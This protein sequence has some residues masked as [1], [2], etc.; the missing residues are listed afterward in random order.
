[1]TRSMGCRLTGF[2]CLT[3]L[4]LAQNASAIQLNGF[5]AMGASETQGTNF[6]GSW[7]P[8]L[9]VDRGLNFGPG[10]KY[11]RAIG[12][13]TSQDLLNNG[14]HTQ[15]ASL[16]AG[17]YVDLAFLS[18][19]G[20]DVPPVAIDM[21]LNP[22]Y[23]VQGWANGV[24][25][26]ILTAVDTVKN[27]GAKGMVVM[28]LPDMSLIPGAAS[29]RPFA[30]PVV[31][32]IDLVNEML[33]QEVLDR[34]FVFVDAAQAMRDMFSSPLVVGGVTINTQTGS[35][36]PTHFFVDN[37]HPG[38]VGN[39]IFANLFLTALNLGYGMNIAEFTDQQILTRAG[40]SGS[41][42]GE[43]SNLDYASYIYVVPE[44]E[45][46]ILL[47]FGVLTDSII[48]ASTDYQRV[49]GATWLATRRARRAAA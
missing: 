2:V 21:I 42:T 9:A 8:Y 40:L 39:G 10:Q 30:A 32:A 35:S 12:G 5:A 1:M 7:V 47:V 27:A 20:L 43:T 13:N 37:I 11:N 16:V 45:S 31:S 33:K 48:M 18:I 34:G 24:V 38:Y 44:P 19:G 25:S 28:S 14:Q 46:L 3:L 23:N 17:G 4:A 41:Y 26:R 36:N 6:N 49:A 29:Y 15:V 22:D